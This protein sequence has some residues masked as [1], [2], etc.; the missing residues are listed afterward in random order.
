MAAAIALGLPLTLPGSDSTER[1]K[2]LSKHGTA[3]WNAPWPNEAKAGATE[4]EIVREDAKRNEYIYRSRHFEFRSDIR[5]S[6]SVVNEFSR[7]FEATWAALA[8]V[9][10]N[11]SLTAHKNTSHFVTRLFKSSVGYLQAGGPRGSGGVYKGSTG[12]VLIPLRSLGV[13]VVGRRV[14]LDRESSNE[15]L[16]H[17]LV[18]QL[19]ANDQRGVPHW[20]REGT[21]EYFSALPYRSG[22][23]S[24]TNPAEFTLKSLGEPERIDFPNLK[25]YLNFD[26]VQFFGA[27]SGVGRG[28]AANYHRSLLVT[29]YF[30]HL[31]GEGDGARIKD[32]LKALRKGTPAGKAVEL[33]LD[34]RSYAQLGEAFAKAWRGK[35]LRVYFVDKGN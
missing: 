31:D 24:F 29:T 9:P 25:S 22:R 30:F 28:G 18:H 1:Q 15:T 35:G 5:I 14:V 3:T 33:L 20:Y 11:H 23:F 34:G 2:L 32:Y 12:E 21:A 10:L 8:A 16:I 6:R 4:I 27:D 13:R 26:R 19:T 17:E 7:I